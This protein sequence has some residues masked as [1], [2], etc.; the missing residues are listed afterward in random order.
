MTNPHLV[1]VRENTE[2]ALRNCARIVFCGY[3]L[4]DA[5]IH[6]K[7]LLKRAQVNRSHGF[8]LKVTIINNHTNKIPAEREAEEKRYIRLLGRS[9]INYT[10]ASF[11]AFSK[12][13]KNFMS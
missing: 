2:A 12:N 8:P 4:P 13:P 5:D 3:S 6:I 10:D 7:Y 1:Q 11:E 9:A